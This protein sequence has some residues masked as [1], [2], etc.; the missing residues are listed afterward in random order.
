MTKKRT[1]RPLLMPLIIL[2][3]LYA[4]AELTRL[5]IQYP[6][7]PEPLALP[8]WQAALELLVIWG[9]YIA[10]MALI[11]KNLKGDKPQ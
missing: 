7:L 11:W 8:V 4:P 9:G 10:G 1:P 6:K 5:I 3:T 2:L